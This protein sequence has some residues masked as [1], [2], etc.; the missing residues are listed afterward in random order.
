MN[1]DQFLENNWPLDL[2][3]Q[4]PRLALLLTLLNRWSMEVRRTQ[5][6]S[7]FLKYYPRPKFRIV[8]C[9]RGTPAPG[10]FPAIPPASASASAPV[11]V[12]AFPP[13][14]APDLLPTRSRWHVLC[15]QAWD[16]CRYLQIRATG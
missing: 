12:P 5:S 6:T 2:E 15:D 1:L 8:L 11:S 7:K 16:H 4:W 3:L 10:A 13:A 14:I 9:V